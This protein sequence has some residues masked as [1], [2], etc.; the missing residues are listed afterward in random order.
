MLLLQR[1]CS[2][3]WL[4]FVSF[5]LISYLSIRSKL[6]VAKFRSTLQSS[7]PRPICVILIHV[8]FVIYIYLPKLVSN[9]IFISDDWCSCRIKV[10]Q[11]VSLV[12]QEV[13]TLSLHPSSHRFVVGLHL[14]NILSSV[15][16]F[17]DIIHC[18]H[19]VL[20][21]GCQHDLVDRYGIFVSQMTRDIF[22]LSQPLPGPFLIH[23]LSPG[24]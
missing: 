21:Y 6:R 2:L 11:R 7:T 20:L 22:H 5:M 15:C 13:L 4:V 17:V 10:T 24:V 14:L 3:I 16:C 1:V 23:D 12:K 9:T 18:L 19:F 8:L